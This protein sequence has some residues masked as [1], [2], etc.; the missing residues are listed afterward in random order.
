VYSTLLKYQVGA[1]AGRYIHKN[2]LPHN[3]VVTMGVD[4][5]LNSLQFYAQG[6]IA[7]IDNPT[8]LA[9]RKY[10]LT[11]DKGLNLL[12]QNGI[13]YHVLQHGD[14]YKVSELTPDFL[15]PQTRSKAVKHYY[16]VKVGF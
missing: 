12:K 1:Q 4:D 5:P 7:G 9:G 10:I 14:F 8:E 3:Q 2:E 15:N 16:L 11:M 6:T 13:A